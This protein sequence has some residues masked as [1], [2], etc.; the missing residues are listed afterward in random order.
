MVERLKLLLGEAA[1]N[2]NDAQLALCLE[3]A[4]AEVEGYCQRELDIELKLLAERIAIIKLNRLGS[5][6]LDSESFSGISQ[7]YLN[8]YPD[9]IKAVLNRKRRIKCY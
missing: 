1:N 6:G 9:D 2:Y 4:K 3:M 7:S 8:D 5:E